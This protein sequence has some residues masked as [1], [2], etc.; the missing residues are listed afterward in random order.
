MVFR[1]TNYCDMECIHCMQDSTTKGKHATMEVIDKMI[2][3]AELAPLTT[4][5]Q[6]SGGEPTEHPEFIKIL[7][8]VLKTFSPRPIT[9]IT[10]GEGFYNK[11]QLKKVLKLMQKYPNL[12]IQLISVKGIYKDHDERV[13]FLNKKFTKIKKKY[14]DEIERRMV[15]CETLDHGI[16]PV[17]RAL[18]NIDKIKEVSF[19]AHRK[20]PSCFNMYN[21]LSEHDGELFKAIDYVKTHSMTSFCK[22]MIKEDGKVVFGEYDMCSTIIDLAE[23]SIENMENMNSMKVDIDQV[24]GPCRSCVNNEHMES[25]I[26]Q[27]LYK[28]KQSSDTKEKLLE[29][30]TSKKDSA[31]AIL[32][33]LKCQK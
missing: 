6:L 21:S 8:K 18:K 23:I 11:D 12:L 20:S 24:L 25:V 4:T 13:K 9:I 14:G 33:E 10:N 32:K 30:K 16:I 2:R 26:D 27:Y 28:F 15:L 7:K 1:I 22:P 3:F 31:L 19:I 5:I 17:G 29:E